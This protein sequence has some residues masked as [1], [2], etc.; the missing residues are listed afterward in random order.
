MRQDIDTDTDCFEF[1]S[2]FEDTASDA[3]AMEH[4]TES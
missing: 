2:G 1:G 3:S 4:Q